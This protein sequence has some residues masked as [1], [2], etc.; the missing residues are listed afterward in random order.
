[1]ALD[2]RLEFHSIISSILVFPSLGILFAC[3]LV[4]A[5]RHGSWAFRIGTL[6]WMRFFGRYSYGIY[7]FHT[8]IH[9]VG[10]MLWLQSRTHSLAIGGVLYVIIMFVLTTI[11]AVLSYELYER[12]FLKLKSR[13]S[14]SAELATP[15]GS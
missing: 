1:L 10:M 7:I 11:A 9:S 14:Y 8:L 2:H 15:A 4:T 3:L 13:F 12:H 5:L 6:R